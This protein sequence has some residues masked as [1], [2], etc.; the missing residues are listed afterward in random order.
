M[1][2]GGGDIEDGMQIG[3]HARGSRSFVRQRDL[4]N[5]AAA[6]AAGEKSRESETAGLWK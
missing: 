4:E 5:T 1:R 2:G 6:A 3:D